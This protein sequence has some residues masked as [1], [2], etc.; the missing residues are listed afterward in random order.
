MSFVAYEAIARRLAHLDER[1]QRG[2]DLLPL[3]SEFECELCL[4]TGLL[5][6]ASGE[7]VVCDCAMGAD[8]S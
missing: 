2:H 3:L 4:D 5:N 6:T 8:R 1:R 7:L